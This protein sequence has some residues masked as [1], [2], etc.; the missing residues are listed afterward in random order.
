VKRKHAAKN[1]HVNHIVA[2]SA[3]SGF[4]DFHPFRRVAFLAARNNFL[5]AYDI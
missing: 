4:F 1:G 2:F 3:L 5:D